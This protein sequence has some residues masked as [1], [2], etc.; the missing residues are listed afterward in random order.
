MAQAYGKH[1][2]RAM[3]SAT[4]HIAMQMVRTAKIPKDSRRIGERKLSGQ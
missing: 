4:R 2:A 3:G 1:D